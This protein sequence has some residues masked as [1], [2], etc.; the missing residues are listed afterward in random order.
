[1]AKKIEQNEKHMAMDQFDKI[2]K[3]E[4]HKMRPEGSDA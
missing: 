3:H 2:Q 4:W 1:M